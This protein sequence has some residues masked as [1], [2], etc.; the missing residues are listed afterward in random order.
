MPEFHAETPDS[1]RVRVLLVE[2]LDRLQ[3]GGTEGLCSV[4][5]QHP[6]LAEVLL[7]RFLLLAQLGL[8]P[9]PATREQR[10]DPVD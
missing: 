10:K 2:C 5:R 3:D 6:E 8:L 9:D 1:A 4:L 7:H